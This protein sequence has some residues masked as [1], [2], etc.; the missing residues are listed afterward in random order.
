M[1]GSP[2]VL[3][4]IA[5]QQTDA[6]TSATGA[7]SEAEAGAGITFADAQAAF[8]PA[9][10]AMTIALNTLNDTITEINTGEKSAITD[11]D[12]TFAEVLETAGVPL[13]D[14]LNNAVE[15]MDRW[16]AALDTHT[17]AIN[18]I[19]TGETDA[20]TGVNDDFAELLVTAGVP[21]TDALNN[22]VEPM[23]RWTA[24]LDTHTTA[25]NDINTGET[26]AIGTVDDRFAEVLETA[27]VPL[28]H[29]LNNAQ[30]PMTRFATATEQFNTSI[31]TINDNEISLLDTE[32]DNFLKFLDVAGVTLP[33]ALA[34]AVEPLDRWTAALDTHSHCYNGY[35][36]G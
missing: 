35:Q 2:T 27:G 4:N 26:S 25:I 20:I 36:H 22:A 23:D 33:D 34:N 12:D 30:E 11:V 31:G 8:V 6:Q 19:N 21:L 29:A 7:I 24:A 9:A 13:T 28:T 3:E 18:R 5:T 1:N 16:T 15:P 17:T 10:D 14:A 32:D